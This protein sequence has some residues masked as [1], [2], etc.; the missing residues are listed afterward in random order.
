MYAPY[1][2]TLV[3]NPY[4]LVLAAFLINIYNTTGR[5]RSHVK[6]CI[7]PDGRLI[8]HWKRRIW[9][10]YASCTDP[11]LGELCARTLEILEFSFESGFGRER[12]RVRARGQRQ[13][14]GS[15]IEEERVSGC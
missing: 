5:I 15:E 4:T 7:H 1:P 13:R 12:V 3:M 6:V 14:P 10:V 2:H 8:H 11:H 9:G